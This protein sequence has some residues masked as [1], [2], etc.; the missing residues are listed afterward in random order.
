[1]SVYKDLTALSESIH[2][3]NYERGWWLE[4]DYFSEGRYLANLVASKIALCHSE[5]SEALEGIRKGTSDTHLPH[6]PAVEVE[7]ADTIIRILDLA[8]FL[9]CDIGAAIEEKLVYNA[10]RLDHKLSSRSK[11]GG[12]LI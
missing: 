3:D 8:A 6:R 9:N 5:L 2:T 1:M 7:L 4:E 12:K 10:K 11:T